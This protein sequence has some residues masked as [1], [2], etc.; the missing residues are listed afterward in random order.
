MDTSGNVGA[1]SGEPTK[2]RRKSGWDTG[3]VNAEGTTVPAQGT[4]F[5]VIEEV[6]LYL[7]DL[8]N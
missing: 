1:D 3:V 6:R 2:R 8:Y 5:G 4:V 7:F